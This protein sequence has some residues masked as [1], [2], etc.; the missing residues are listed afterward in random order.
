MALGLTSPFRTSGR[1]RRCSAWSSSVSPSTCGLSSGAR[2][3]C[4]PQSALS[5]PPA[6]CVGA[7]LLAD[8]R[9]SAWLASGSR[10][11]PN[12]VRRRSPG[13]RLRPRAI[14]LLLTGG[15]G[16]GDYVPNRPPPLR[17]AYLLPSTSISGF[18]KFPQDAADSAVGAQVGQVLEGARK[19]PR[20]GG[21]RGESGPQVIQ[22]AALAEPEPA[23]PATVYCSVEHELRS[24]CRVELDTPGGGLDFPPTHS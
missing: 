6:S 3:G 18:P 11:I 1:P 22:G 24:E 23:R 7:R 4:R 5:C 21:E 2:S 20:R 16:P 8:R 12:G 19:A 10:R 17:P 14:L 13:V 15:G 9:S